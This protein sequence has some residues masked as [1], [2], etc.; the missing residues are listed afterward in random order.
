MYIEIYQIYSHCINRYSLIY[1]V[2]GSFNNRGNNYSEWEVIT[3]PPLG[4]IAIGTI[5]HLTK[6]VL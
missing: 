4:S 2:T 3:M 6:I 1:V 5:V